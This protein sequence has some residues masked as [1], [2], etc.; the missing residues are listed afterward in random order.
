E[1]C[2]AGCCP[3]RQPGRGCRQDPTFAGQGARRTCPLQ[4]RAQ[5]AQAQARQRKIERRALQVATQQAQSRRAQVSVGGARSRRAAQI[6]RA[7]ADPIQEAAAEPAASTPAAASSANSPLEMPSICISVA[8]VCWPSSGGAERT[9]P[10]VSERRTGT[11][12]T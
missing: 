10:G 7:L 5:P 4:T 12:V 8:I 3:R 6:A 1:A 2:S 11:P 9:A